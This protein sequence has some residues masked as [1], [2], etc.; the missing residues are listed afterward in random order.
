MRG[1][2]LHLNTQYTV[3]GKVRAGQ[4]VVEGLEVGTLGQGFGFSP[5][6]IEAV[7]VAS[8]LEGAPRVEVM[9]TNSEI[10]AA[11]LDALRD[12]SGALPDLCAIDV[13][14]RITN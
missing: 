12:S 3:W 6:F 10:F 2:A 8:D 9:D 11:Y 1:N 7:E 13:P 4:D 14:V 5:D